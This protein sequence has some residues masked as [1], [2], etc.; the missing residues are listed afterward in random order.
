MDKRLQEMLDHYEIRK[1]V[2]EYC[3]GVDRMDQVAMTSVYA[4]DSWDDHGPNKCSGPEFAQRVMKL[5]QSAASVLGS[6]MLGQTLIMVDGDQAGAET[7]FIA[8]SRKQ[9]EDGSEILNQMGGRYVDALVREYDRWKIKRRVCV[10]DWSNS[11]PITGDWLGRDA[12]VQGAR[13]DEDP[14][15][16]AL[17]IK[18]SG[19]ASSP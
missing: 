10:H 2:S 7:Y 4:E 19:A 12:Y 3:R 5:M 17:G 15:F 14:S 13:S 8:T 11:L 1:T 6:H 16:A 18:H 9:A